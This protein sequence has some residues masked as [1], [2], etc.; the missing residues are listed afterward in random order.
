MASSRRLDEDIVGV[1]TEEKAYELL[2]EDED[3]DKAKP[4]KIIFLPAHSY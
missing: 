2:H 1:E 3:K 4:S